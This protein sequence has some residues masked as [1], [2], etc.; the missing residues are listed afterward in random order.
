MLV[1]SLRR[2]AFS[3]RTANALKLLQPPALNLEIVAIGGLPLYNPDLEDQTPFPWVEFRDAIRAVDAVLF[4][5]PEYNRSVPGALK[6][7][8]DVGSRPYG[9]SAWEGKPCGVVSCSPG[10]VGGFGAN[11]A[12]RQCLV[13]LDMPAMPQP[14]VYLGGVDKLIDGDGKVLND[15]TRQFLEKYLQK[16][17]SWIE[18]NMR[19]P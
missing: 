17:G 8:I 5:T 10:A 18:V 3:L 2:E 15:K 12:L 9:K 16:F 14:E 6:N 1:G 7:A 13:F 19:A 11:H 4:V